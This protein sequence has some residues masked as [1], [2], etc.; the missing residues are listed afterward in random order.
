MR[1]ND[2]PIKPI[3]KNKTRIFRP[4]EISKLLHAIPKPENRDKFEALLYTGCRYR[5][6][7]KLYKNKKNFSNNTIYIP[8]TKKKSVYSSR[9]VR[10]NT[11]GI[12][13]VSYFIRSKTNLPSYAS[14]KKNLIRW[15]EY[16]GIDPEGVNCK[17]TRKTWESWL[18]STYQKN[19][20]L[21]FLSQGHTQ[22]TSLKYYLMIPF[23]KQDLEEMKYYTQGW[24]EE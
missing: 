20:E 6:L 22:M 4:S 12:R 24:I 7:Q 11:L 3:L 14:W 9:Y 10:L 13:S 18:V 5:E 23:T 16:A 15:C 17:S 8:S 21:I 2:Q 19:L 1:K